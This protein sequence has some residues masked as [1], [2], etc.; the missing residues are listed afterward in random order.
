[1]TQ[2]HWTWALTII[3]EAALILLFRHVWDGQGIPLYV[4]VLAA[5]GLGGLTCRLLLWLYRRLVHGV[6]AAWRYR[7]SDAEREARD[8]RD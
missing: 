1:M 7:E 6:V 2:K 8:A 5:G 3:T 4:Q